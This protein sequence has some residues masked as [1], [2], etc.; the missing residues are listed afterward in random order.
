[1]KR[2]CFLQ[3][4]IPFLLSMMFFS[5]ASATL[6]A[7]Q[8]EDWAMAKG[9]EILNI[10]AEPTSKQKYEAL[11][12]ILTQDIN[13]DYAAKFVVGKYWR[14]MSEEQQEKYVPLFKRYAAALYKNFPLNIPNGAVEFKIEKTVQDKDII[15]IFGRI[16]VTELNNIN[17]QNN[18]G[19]KVQFLLEENNN[20]P[21]VRDLKVEESSLLLTFRERFYKMI[22]Q[23][24][25]DEID[26]FLEDFETLVIDTENKRQM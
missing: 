8:A 13:L 20:R 10:L 18:D 26:W 24:N 19:F 25:D 16:Y 7:K 22:H 17:Q 5:S 4:I 2:K 6:T 12:K 9:Q 21:Q 15:N 11:D 3:L 23:D 14:T 1:M